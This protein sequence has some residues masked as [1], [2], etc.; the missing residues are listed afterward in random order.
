MPRNEQEWWGSQDYSQGRKAEAGRER[1]MTVSWPGQSLLYSVD[2]ETS[3]V[4]PEVDF[5]RI[6][7]FL[8]VDMFF[9]P[10]ID[11]RKSHG[12]KF[13]IENLC[14]RSS[15]RHDWA[16]PGERPRDPVEMGNSGKKETLDFSRFCGVEPVNTRL[17]NSSLA[18]YVLTY[19][20]QTLILL[21]L[22]SY[23]VSQLMCT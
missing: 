6:I 23:R 11:Q 9:Q 3:S 15:R 19:L 20:L 17:N 1:V 13:G 2:N 5:V 8:K 4:K 18:Y 22:P 16:H 7:V 10:R 21:L 12:H 14:G